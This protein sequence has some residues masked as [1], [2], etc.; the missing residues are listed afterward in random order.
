M[1]SRA[2]A[3]TAKPRQH[4]ATQPA[5]ID[6]DAELAGTV[7]GEHVLVIGASALEVMCTLQRKG[8][9]EVMLLRQGAKPEQH[10][11]DLAIA[12]AVRTLEQATSALAQAGRALT[13]SG[14][15]ILR[16]VADSTGRLAQSVA[17]MLRLHG[18]SGVRVRQTGEG[19]LVIGTRTWFG[20]VV[21][22]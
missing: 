18:F 12:A 20:P 6:P 16:M 1:L 2:R 13:E 22:A 5:H 11:A 3:S 9:A 10:T 19:A 17:Q 4:A 15:V 8:A 14:R 7:R 21:R